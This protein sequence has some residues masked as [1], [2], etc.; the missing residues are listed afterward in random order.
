MMVSLVNS[1]TTAYIAKFASGQQSV[2]VD[3]KQSSLIL[4]DCI[5]QNTL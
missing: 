3:G 2:V 5:Q 1:S 4:F